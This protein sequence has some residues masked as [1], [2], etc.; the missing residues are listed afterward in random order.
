VGR[1]EEGEGQPTNRGRRRVR[2]RLTE[3]GKNV[4]DSFNF[5]EER[6]WRPRSWTEGHRGR[7]GLPREGFQRR[8]RG[9]RKVRTAATMCF[10]AVRQRRNGG[11]EGP[12]GGQWPRSMWSDG[13][14]STRPSG[15]GGSPRTAALGRA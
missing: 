1:G 10:K 2:K 5:G 14:C 9:E 3:G 7:G 15:A 13:G 8:T 11:G 6:A 12:E 4:G